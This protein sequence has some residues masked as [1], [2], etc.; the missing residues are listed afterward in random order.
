MSD[1]P[2]PN[3]LSKIRDTKEG[4]VK[5]LLSKTP[6]DKLLVDARATTKKNPPRDFFHAVSKESDTINLIA[7]VKKASPSK[8]LI[9]ADF[10]PEKIAKAYQAGGASA[11]SCL[12]DETYF[13]GKLQYLKEVKDAVD[14]PVLR[15]DFIISEAQIAEA[16]IWGADAVLLIARMLDLETLEKLHALA[17]EL[18]L[19]ALCEA[20]DEEDIEKCLACNV[21]LIGINNRDL[22]TF[23]VDTDTAIRL[24]KLIPDSIPVVAESGIFTNADICD[25]LKNKIPAALVGESLMRQD[26]VKLA[27]EQLINKIS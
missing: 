9:R 15:K 24:K 22:D 26:D 7:E 3:I 17:D 10:N 2:L 14:I 13:K 1:R 8:G 20:H 23:L 16:R 11:I 6:L 19:T 25:L 4:E 18:K 12:T 5:A 27:T 21:K